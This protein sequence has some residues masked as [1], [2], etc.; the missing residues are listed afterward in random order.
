MITSEKRF[1]PKFSTGREEEPSPLSYSLPSTFQ[2]KPSKTPTVGF[3]SEPR[4][5][6]PPTRKADFGAYNL[7]LPGAFPNVYTAEQW[8]SQQKLLLEETHQARIS[9]RAPAP[10][11][12]LAAGPGSYNTDS[13]ILKT[14]HECRFSK[15]KRL[16]MTEY[17]ESLGQVGAS[18]GPK[19]LPDA[20]TIAH[21]YGPSVKSPTKTPKSPR[22]M[23]EAAKSIANPF[24]WPQRLQAPVDIKQSGPGSYDL[25]TD[26][27]KKTTKRGTFGTAKQMDMLSNLVAYGHVGVTPTGPGQYDVPPSSFHS[28]TFNTRGGY[29]SPTKLSQ[30]LHTTSKETNEVAAKMPPDEIWR[31]MRKAPDPLHLSSHDF[32]VRRLKKPT[33]SASTTA[34][35]TSVPATPTTPVVEPTEEVEAEPTVEPRLQLELP[36]EGDV[37]TGFEL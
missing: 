17:I 34:T 9:P 5:K 22:L 6:S 29:R 2:P 1:G 21:R 16:D 33:A 14:G 8:E 11:L 28:K 26:F 20:Y 30:A 12:Q 3:G 32:G 19:Y 7:E 24:L 37:L 4:L 18:P 23:S 13:D 31:A 27:V 36:P 35:V 25:G 15:A 10:R